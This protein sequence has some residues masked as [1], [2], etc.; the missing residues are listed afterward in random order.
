MGY[1]NLY[2]PSLGY[3]RGKDSL[4]KWRTPFDPHG[5][6]DASRNND[7]T[8]GASWQYSW[9]VPQD[10]PGMIKLFGGKDAFQ[11]ENLSEQNIYI[12]S[13]TLNGK[14]WDSPMLPYKE[15]K[16]GGAIVF[17]MGSQ[18]NKSWGTNGCQ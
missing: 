11:A 14:M 16:N 7:F 3:M 2:D 13:A 9:Y 5:Y 15:L 10:V 8:E 18:P 17:K 1:T 4:G 6:D 12:Q